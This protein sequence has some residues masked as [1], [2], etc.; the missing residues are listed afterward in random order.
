MID[1]F[2]RPQD[3]KEDFELLQEEYEYA[4]SLSEEAFL[5]EYK[6]ED[7]QEEYLEFVLGEIQEAQKRIE[8]DEQ[9]DEERYEEDEIVKTFGSYE[10]C[11]SQ[12]I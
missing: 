8:E 9:Y 5:A 4:S 10:N 11:F 12:F 6:E 7:D 3:H 1:C 2:N